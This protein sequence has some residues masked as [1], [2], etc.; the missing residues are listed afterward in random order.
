[1]LENKNENENPV[2]ISSKNI[3]KTEHKNLDDN[4][5]D[6]RKKIELNNIINNNIDINFY[7]YN[8]NK[9]IRKNESDIL[10]N[11]INNSNIN[12]LLNNDFLITSLP[13]IK[14]NSYSN[15]K[16]NISKTNNKEIK[17]E[18]ELLNN[19]NNI[20]K[21]EEIIPKILFKKNNSTSNLSTDTNQ[22]SRYNNI[23]ISN[24]PNIKKLNIVIHENIT[25]REK[26]EENSQKL[27][28]LRNKELSILK[29]RKMKGDG[30]ESN[31]N[32]IF[33]KNFSSYK[34]IKNKKNKY[35]Y[36]SME[37]KEKERLDEEKFIV[38]LE[39]EK[40]KLKLLPISNEELS[41]LSSC[42]YLPK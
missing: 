28:D 29:E 32:K 16:N 21:N 4:L 36:I 9:I 11:N 10:I 17:N 33:P 2:N 1:M 40:R 8:N 12:Y 19:N 13:K 39:N 24:F 41:F 25:E 20:I 6:I 42:L 38:S 23:L 14:N 30:M 18:K 7:K 3:L 22:K 37:E 35:L 5:E 27:R 26:D 31:F 15:K 34:F